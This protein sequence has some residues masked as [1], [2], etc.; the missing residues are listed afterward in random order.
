L[1]F[2]AIDIETVAGQLLDAVELCGTEAFDQHKIA[3]SRKLKRIITRCV[4][5]LSP[6]IALA[7]AGA[8]LLDG[9]NRS[10]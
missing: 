5:G 1:L 2:L 3:G 7:A 10:S 4:L 6:C 8:G 9:K